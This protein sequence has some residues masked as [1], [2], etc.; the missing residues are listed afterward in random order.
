MNGSIPKRDYFLET[1]ALF[2][3]SDGIQLSFF[4]SMLNGCELSTTGGSVLISISTDLQ[5]AMCN[6]I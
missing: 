6:D 2:V 1:R 4:L 3:Q 5:N